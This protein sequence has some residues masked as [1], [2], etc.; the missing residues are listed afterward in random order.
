MRT[1]VLGLLVIVLGACAGGAGDDASPEETPTTPSPTPAVTGALVGTFG[2]DAQLEGGCAW[3]ESEG[4]R[5]EVLFPEGYEVSFEPL[6]LVGPDGEVVATEGDELALDGQAVTDM[7]TICQIG[8]VFR[9]ES[10]EPA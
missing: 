9:A 1:V 10:V 2:G 7:A 8:P 6:T 4:T 3:V 5:Y